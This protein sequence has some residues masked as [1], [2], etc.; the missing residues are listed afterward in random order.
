[1]LLI[2]LSSSGPLW[3]G[4]RRR[5]PGLRHK[6][7]TAPCKSGGSTN[8]GA[9]RRADLCLDK[10]QTPDPNNTPLFRWVPTMEVQGHSSTPHCASAG[11]RRTGS[12]EFLSQQCSRGAQG[13][14]LPC[15]GIWE[16]RKRPNPAEQ[17]SQLP[18]SGSS[19][20]HPHNKVMGKGDK[21]RAPEPQSVNKNIPRSTQKKPL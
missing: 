21:K 20:H 7:D 5:R 15:P 2:S 3:W 6:G 17:H 11:V 4:W 12:R 14:H 1:M 16:P 13:S 9:P 8:P 19:Q 10:G 18:E